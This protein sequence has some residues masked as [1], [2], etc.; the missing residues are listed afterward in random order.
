[1]DR[2]HYSAI[3]DAVRA[4]LQSHRRVRDGTLNGKGT[5]LSDARYYIFECSLG[6]LRRQLAAAGC[7]NLHHQLFSTA[8]ET[9]A[10]EALRTLAREVGESPQAP[11]VAGAPV[12]LLGDASAALLADVVR[13]LEEF[14]SP[15]PPSETPAAP[16]PPTVPTRLQQITAMVDSLTDDDWEDTTPLIRKL[17]LYMKSRE[18]ADLPDLCPAVWGEDCAN[19]SDRARDTL[20][21]KAN[22][23]LSK[24]PAKWRLS[25]LR[26]QPILLWQ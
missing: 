3:A 24:R 22:R 4:L 11:L 19:V 1:M 5:R 21:S 18:R 15:A 26:G 14:L 9:V 17:L 7:F 8:E 6:E 23:F 2:Q 13:A 25:K 10:Y 12:P 20:V 16:Q